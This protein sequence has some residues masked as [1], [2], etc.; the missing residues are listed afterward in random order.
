[1][2]TK[3]K[4]KLSKKEEGNFPVEKVN[5]SRALSPFEEMD[6]MFED[7]FP[8]RWMQP[9]RW[10]MPHWPELT[11]LKMPK[12]DV[13]DHDTEVVVKAELPG[14]QKDDINVS[15]TDS[16]VTIKG[17]TSHE[18]KEEK[19]NY[20]RRE[21]SRGSFS[22]TVALPSDVDA[23]KA[24]ANFTDGILVLTIPKVEKSHRKSVTVE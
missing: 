21:I 6:H 3:S 4:G 16:S 5:P 11:E 1:M 15:V 22:R 12:V 7:F 8:R 20:Y 13:I 19:G 24:K 18:E 17:S 10:E 14:V 9:F 2:T 23:D